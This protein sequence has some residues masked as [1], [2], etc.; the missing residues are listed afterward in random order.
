MRE[1]ES[2]KGGLSKAIKIFVIIAIII[3]VVVGAGYIVLDKIL[4]EKDNGNLKLAINFTNVTEKTR[5]EIYMENDVL[6]LSMDDI[7]NYYDKNIY[8]DSKYNQIVTSSEEKLAVLKLDESSIEV[9]GEKKNIKGAAK[10]KNKVYYLPISDMEEVYNIK[11]KKVNNNIAIESLDKKSKKG[12]VKKNINLKA[13]AR[14]LSGNIEKIKKG[15]EVKIAETDQNSMPDGWIKVRTENGRIGYIKEKDVKDIVIE[16]EEKESLKFVDGKVS[17]AWDYFS[18]Y[19]KAPDNTGKTYDGVNVVSPSFFYLD[20]RDMQK[21]GAIAK[22]SKEQARIKENVGTSGEAYIKWAHSNG[23]KVW[24]MVS[25]ETISTTID[26]FSEIINDYELR[27]I[28]IND[29]ISYVEKYDLDGI[30]IDFEYMYSEDKDSFTKFI[31][32]LAP[33]LRA[34]NACLSVDV[35]APDGDKDWS[36]C[37]NRNVIGNVADYIVLMGYDQ[38]G[39]NGLGSTSEYKWVDNSIN[40]MIKYDEVPTEKFV[41]GLPLY[42]KLW[43]TKDGKKVGNP[44]TI[45]MRNMKSNISSGL[46]KD[47]LEDAQQYFI[48]YERGGYLYKIWIEDEE[49][50]EKKLLLVNQYDL[51]GAAYWRKGFDSDEVWNIVKDVLEVKQ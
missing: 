27:K 25:N 43:K 5:Q 36:E 42:T 21:T 49:S 29:I 31:I 9:N 45:S 26:E 19:V 7:K 18:Q 13:K 15:S 41:L 3:G 37:Y 2:K 17:M 48:Q 33:R 39:A 23:Y 32:E 6:Y 24:P 8:F 16:R 11:V 10:L 47:W 14:D 46:K 50:F 51:A 30:N 40:K 12:V 22:D 44:D 38:Y 4:T 20:L 35:T 1:K 34:L 28:M